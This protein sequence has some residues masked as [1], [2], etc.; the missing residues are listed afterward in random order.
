M[1]Y[2]R[3]NFLHLMKNLE[4]FI[5]TFFVY[6]FSEILRRYLYSSSITSIDKRVDKRVYI[7]D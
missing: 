1:R 4:S 3:S 2:L 5:H 6:T 7:K